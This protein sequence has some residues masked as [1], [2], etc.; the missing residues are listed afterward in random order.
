MIVK[1]PKNRSAIIDSKVSLV[2]YDAFVRSEDELLKSTCRKN[3][4]KAF[5][6]HID[7]LSAKDYAKYQSGTLQY[8]FMFVPIE[9]AFS[10]AVQED[11]LLYEYALKK[12]IAIVTPST[13][14]VSLRTIY[15]YW[16][17]ENSTANANILFEEAGKLYDKM[18][19]FSENFIKIGSNIDKL[20]K[21]F[22]SAK[23]QLMSGNGNLLTRV[24]KL[25]ALV[26]KLQKSYQK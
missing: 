18:Y 8:I 17:S 6:N 13:L 24:T 5:K 10:L 7:T 19:I 1:L 23:S 4:V 22:D 12:H 14:T 21:D 3:L 9:G 20:H 11:P 16:Q 15:L 26:Q 25:K 2:D